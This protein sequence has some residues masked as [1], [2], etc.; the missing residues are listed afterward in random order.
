MFYYKDDLGEEFKSKFKG[1]LK[2]RAYFRAVY[3]KFIKYSRDDNS[4]DKNK[5]YSIMRNKRKLKSLDYLEKC[6]D[7]CFK[8][9]DFNKKCLD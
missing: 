3:F 1:E 9:L 7:Y 2:G 5:Y 4:P 8:R 6:L